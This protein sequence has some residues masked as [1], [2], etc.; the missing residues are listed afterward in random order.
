MVDVCR[1]AGVSKATVSR[2]LNNTGPVKESTRQAVYEAIQTLNYRPNGL[3]QALA[4]HRSDT[5]GL[6][7]SNF[8]GSYFGTLLRQATRSADEAGKQLIVTDGHDDPKRELDAV[9]ML[10]DRRCD[11]IVLYS[12]HMPDDQLV[13]LIRELP[14]P[15]IAMNRYLQ[16][17]P[18]RS[19]ALAQVSAAH[20]ATEYL[21]NLGHRRIACITRP[22]HQPTAQARLQG[23]REALLARGVKV[24]ETMIEEGANTIPSGYEACKKLLDRVSFSALVCFTDYMA[25]GAYRALSEKGLRI[26]D[27]VSVFGFDDAPVAAYMVPA[28]STIHVPIEEM[29][30][31]AF[32]QAVRLAAGKEAPPIA[33]FQGRMVLRESVSVV[34]KN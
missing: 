10:V 19:I 12:R 1:L 9:N 13:Q 16:A 32:E 31:T 8:T 21:L 18:D 33:P 3:A 2:V 22:V 28:L 11:A 34:R 4:S 15:L 30:R 7:L 23:Y 25:E 29:T 5:V 27:D 24:E 14:V 6:I 20:M 26:P 17:I